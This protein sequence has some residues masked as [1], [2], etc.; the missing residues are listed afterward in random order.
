MIAR[1]NFVHICFVL[2]QKTSLVCHLGDSAS[3]AYF[4]IASRCVSN[5]SS[6]VPRATNNQARTAKRSFDIVTFCQFFNSSKTVSRAVLWKIVEYRLGFYNL[7]SVTIMILLHLSTW[8]HCS[9]SKLTDRRP[10]TMFDGEQTLWGKAEP[11]SRSSH[12]PYKSRAS[13]PYQIARD[14]IWNQKDFFLKLIISGQAN[15]IMWYFSFKRRTYLSKMEMTQRMIKKENIFVY[16]SEK[17][18]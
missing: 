15:W 8:C 11:Q 7:Q 1:E 14:Q 16:T 12:D 17:I 9:A 18:E 4:S 6:R 3:F 13:D 10:S 2:L 5:M